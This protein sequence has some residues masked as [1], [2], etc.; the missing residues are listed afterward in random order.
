MLK[1]IQIN[2]GDKIISLKFISGHIFSHCCL[3][4]T[5]LH[6]C[7]HARGGKGVEKAKKCAD[8]IYEWSLGK[9]YDFYAVKRYP[10]TSS[11][12]QSATNGKRSRS[13]H[14]LGSGKTTLLLNL[15]KWGHSYFAI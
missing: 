12:W 9:K 1:A 11:Y 13:K 14:S 2:F 15:K 7:N 4:G 5:K 6:N 8:V 3:F 10:C